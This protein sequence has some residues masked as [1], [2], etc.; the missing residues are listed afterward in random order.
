M[1]LSGALIVGLVVALVATPIVARVARRLD[2]VDHPGPLKTQREAVPYLGGVAVFLAVIVG[3]IVAD[4][5]ELI[6]P[7]AA[8]L[9]LGVIDDRRALSPR[10]RLVAELLVGVLAAETLPGD[11]LARVASAVLVVVLINAVNLLDGQDGLVAGCATCSAL[12]FVVLGGDARPVEAALA[13]AL[14]GFFVYNRAPARIYLGD[15]GAYLVGT[16]LALGPALVATSIGPGATSLG[17]WTLG[18]GPVSVWAVWLATP[19]IVAVPLAD[20]AIAVL[21]RARAGHPI[22]AGDRSHVYDQLVDR[23]FTVNRS[24][25]TCVGLQAVLAAAGAGAALLSPV[26]ALVST[27][28][29]SLVL[30]AVAAAAGLLGPGQ[31]RSAAS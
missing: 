23:G 21:R 2:V 26:G 6:I 19:L 12:A 9:A 14:A 27:V 13:G 10:L 8:A 18:S 16:A 15:G 4:R 25:A 1:E 31:A 17:A 30:F 5:A 28:A 22:F 29:A 3:P 11:A 20:T 7:M 24:T